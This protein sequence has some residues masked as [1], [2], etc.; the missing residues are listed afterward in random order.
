[1]FLPFVTFRPP[2][3]RT[4]WRR[5]C[6]RR[7]AISRTGGF[8]LIELLVAV[9]LLAILA[10]LS[11]RGLDAV[12][13]SRERLVRESDELRSLTLALSQLEDDLLATWPVKR[14][15]SGVTPIR[16]VLDGNGA[17]ASQ[18]LLLV[19]EISRTGQATRLQRVVYQVRDGRLERGFSEWQRGTDR[20]G[21]VGGAVQSLIWQPILPDVR[22]LRIR[23]WINN[24]WMGG[25]PLASYT[26]QRSGEHAGQSAD[27]PYDNRSYPNLP[28]IS[29]TT[30]ADVAENIRAERRLYDERKEMEDLNGMEVLV[31]R[32]NGQRFLRIYSIRD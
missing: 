31:E 25:E 19:R 15:G 17:T 12:I 2:V 9:A 30:P 1:M 29:P 23:G 14:I 13:Q 18:S 16:V 7:P 10:V 8:T 5:S 32:T 11:W 4:A 28:G 20:S 21:Q 22:S 6:V 27:D 24:T 26:R 3:L